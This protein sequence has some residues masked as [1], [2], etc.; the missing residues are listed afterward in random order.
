MRA[1]L[2]ACLFAAV[3]VVTGCASTGGTVDY[4]TLVKNA[5]TLGTSELAFLQTQSTIPAADV[6]H[7]AQI[8]TAVTSA[9]SAVSTNPQDTYAILETV[10]IS[11]TALYLQYHTGAAAP[12]PASGAL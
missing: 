7:I 8:N 2:M 3:S 4:S 5:C 9:C 11:L 1:F 10:M 12:A 6:Q